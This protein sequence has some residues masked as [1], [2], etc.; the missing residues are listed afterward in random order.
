MRAS[1]SGSDVRDGTRDEQ[2][3]RAGHSD[4]SG[5]A[6]SR[7]GSV[8]APARILL[9][10]D[11][12]Y[13]LW[14]VASWL[15]TID[16]IEVVGHASSGREALEQVDELGP[17][18]VLMDLVMPEMG[19]LE[20]MRRLAARPRRPRVILISVHDDEEYRAAADAAGADGFVC[21]SELKEKLL[22]LLRSLLIQPTRPEIPPLT[23]NREDA[24]P[25]TLTWK[26]T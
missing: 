15:S 14:V 26:V 24:V 22:P 7:I 9:V 16:E 1:N 5:K 2:T 10:D 20:A 3:G 6:D 21:K 8:I 23:G 18:L 17:D 4:P 11:S 12:P 25:G 19:G 13:F